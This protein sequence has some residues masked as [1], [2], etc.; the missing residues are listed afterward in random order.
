[1]SIPGGS[2]EPGTLNVS[3]FEISVLV[4]KQESEH[5]GFPLHLDS[6]EYKFMSSRSYG[7]YV[8]NTVK[9]QLISQIFTSL[10]NVTSRLCQLD[11]LMLSHKQLVPYSTSISFPWGTL[12]AAIFPHELYSWHPCL[13][14]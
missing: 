4:L 5:L 12:Q 10:G 1:M 7:Y 13:H 8:Y 6:Y 2:S 9:K 14:A 11:L 3:R